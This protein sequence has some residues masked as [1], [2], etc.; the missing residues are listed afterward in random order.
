MASERDAAAAERDH[1]A[2]EVDDGIF[3]RDD[4]ATERDHAH[5]ARDDAAGKRDRS[6][7]NAD[8]HI[9]LRDD[10]ASDRDRAATIRDLAATTRDQAA[11]E[12]ELTEAHT[13]PGA[14]SAF[15]ASKREQAVRDRGLAAA[16]RGHTASERDQIH[17]EA[18]DRKLDRLDA[19]DDREKAV[20]DRAI[21]ADDREQSE[22]EAGLR[23]ADRS[24]AATDR[25][26]ASEDR[27]KAAADRVASTAEQAQSRNELRRA[28]IDQPTGALGRQFGLSALH[29]AVERAHR[30]DSALTIA[31]IRVQGLNHVNDRDGHSTGDALLREVVGALQVHFHPDDPIARMSGD[32]FL[33]ALQ[34]S[35]HDAQRRVAGAE[36]TIELYHHGA[37][38]DVRMAALRSGETLWQLANRADRPPGRSEVGA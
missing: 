8:G 17:K 24:D 34:G 23:D 11:T 3:V 1:V 4:A 21:T 29:S 35:E 7:A 19:A 20:A 25:A 16:D 27:G 12:L 38:I 30:D 13:D 37:S 14:A 5:H 32:H 28:Q 15:R 36:K 10:T 9:D 33:C 6:Q 31:H 26:L 18:D 22:E 2:A